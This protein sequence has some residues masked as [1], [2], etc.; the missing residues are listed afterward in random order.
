MKKNLTNLLA[1]I[2]LTFTSVQLSA[3]TTAQF[4]NLGIGGAAKVSNNGT[5]CSGQ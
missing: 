4:F 5:I 2:V 3:Q 1:L